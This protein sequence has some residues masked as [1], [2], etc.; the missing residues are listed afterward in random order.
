MVDCLPESSSS[1]HATFPI[2][3][4]Q[5]SGSSL[6]EDAKRRR[7][8][9]QDSGSTVVD[10][11]KGTPRITFYETTA[12][13]PKPCNGSNPNDDRHTIQQLGPVSTTPSTC[14]WELLQLVYLC[15]EMPP[16][17]GIH[18]SQPNS[19]SLITGIKKY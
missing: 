11:H 10:N 7:I 13:L 18:I 5:Y 14:P 8:E 12:A 15:L 3:K 6:I 9:H 2:L 1:D 17:Y 16:L 19:Q 4:H